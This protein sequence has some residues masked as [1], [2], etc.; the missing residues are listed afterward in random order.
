M[1]S[2]LEAK[3]TQ[4][5]TDLYDFYPILPFTTTILTPCARHCEG[6]VLVCVCVCGW[7]VIA[8]GAYD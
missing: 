3:E 5:A 6:S 2:L 7:V 4:Y 1:T 8:H